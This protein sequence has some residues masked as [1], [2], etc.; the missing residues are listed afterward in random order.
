MKY[1]DKDDIPVFILILGVIL[2]SYGSSRLVDG[3]GLFVLGIALALY[4]RPL[5]RWIK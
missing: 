3:A 4:A 1:F 2:M 5:S